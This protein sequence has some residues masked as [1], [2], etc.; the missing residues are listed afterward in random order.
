MG[1]TRDAAV[2]IAERGATGNPSQTYNASNGGSFAETII[3]GFFGYQPDLLAPGLVPDAR[4]RG[5]VGE[6][7]NARQG[8]RLYRL[9]STPHGIEVTIE[10]HPTKAYLV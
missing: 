8:G 2:R 3:R 6:L 1:R 4:P 5:F 9:A 7:L 10:V